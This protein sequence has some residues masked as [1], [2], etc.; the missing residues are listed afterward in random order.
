MEIGNLSSLFEVSFALHVGYGAFRSVNHVGIGEIENYEKE[1]MLREIY[2]DRG[3]TYKYGAGQKVHCSTKRKPGVRSPIN[4]L[5]FIGSLL[6]PTVA[7]FSSV[8]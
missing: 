2:I 8:L 6:N 7:H 3:I 5:L 4:T 1:L